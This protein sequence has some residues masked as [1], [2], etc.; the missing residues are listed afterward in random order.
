MGVR[1]AG[2][3]LRRWSRCIGLDGDGQGENCTLIILEE[4]DGMERDG[5][6]DGTECTLS[7][8]PSKGYSDIWIY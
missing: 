6:M 5:V 3:R 7:A 8:E 2:S 1:S 4:W